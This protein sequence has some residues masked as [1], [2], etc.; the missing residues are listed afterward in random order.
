MY[1]K[2]LV[3]ADFSKHT[4][5][6]LECVGEIPKVKE[7]VLLHI[8]AG[9]PLARVGPLETKSRRLTQNWNN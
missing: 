8:V 7:V 9:D 6:V 1:E 4:N 2:V 5:P 3:P